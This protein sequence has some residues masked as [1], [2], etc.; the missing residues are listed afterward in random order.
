MPGACEA[1]PGTREAARVTPGT[2]R[3]P[4]GRG[5]AGGRCRGR[6]GSRGVEPGR[7]GA[8]PGAARCAGGAGQGA[9][10]G[11]RGRARGEPPGAHAGRLCEGRRKGRG[12]EEREGE[13]RGAHLGVQIR[14]PLSPKPRAPRGREREVAERRLMRGKIE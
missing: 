13:W 7:G 3:A 4:P 9:T 5:R 8:P 1:A 14:R 2:G 11:A 10:R 12:G 6:A